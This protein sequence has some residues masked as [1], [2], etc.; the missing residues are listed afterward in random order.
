M[1]LESILEHI[2]SQANCQKDKIIETAKEEAD[3]IIQAAKLEADKLFQESLEKE[4][5]LYLAG[6]QKRL[7]EA[8]LEAKRQIL[9]SKQELISHVFEKLKAGLDKNRFKKER[10]AS[11]KVEEVNED[12]DFYLNK[13]RP[14]YEAQIA[15]ILFG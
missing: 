7:V 5:R 12:L 9:E 1:S 10:I 13:I 6:Q 14:D 4:K 2:L 15:K 11:D 3:K 8:H